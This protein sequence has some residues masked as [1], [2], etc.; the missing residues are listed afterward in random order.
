MIYSIYGRPTNSFNLSVF[1]TH[2]IKN[3][4]MG[5]QVNKTFQYKNKKYSGNLGIF[6]NCTLSLPVGGN[7][8]QVLQL[9]HKKFHT[10]I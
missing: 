8:F 2:N 5:V 7:V 1:N 10:L 4:K 9:Y 3:L 6:Q